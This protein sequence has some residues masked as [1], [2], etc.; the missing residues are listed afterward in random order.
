MA[1]QSEKKKIHFKRVPAL[2]KGFRMLEILS[3]AQAPMGVTELADR[4]GFHKSTVFNIMYTL[5]DLGVLEKAPANKVRLGMKFYTLSRPSAAG[6]FMISKIRPFLE[7]INRK[8]KLSVFLGVRSALKAVILDKVD[9]TQEI[10]VSSSRGMKIPLIAGSHGKALLSLLPE[11]QL[12]E[13]LV[14][15]NL[16]KFTAHTCTNPQSFK[17][18]VRK[19]A[20]DRFALDNEE[21]LEGIRSMAIPLNLGR[22]DVQTAIWLVGLKNQIADEMIPNFRDLLKKIGLQIETLFSR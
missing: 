2:D 22:P 19:T 20:R 9:S 16:K 6:V 3:E 21:Y 13:I 17:N 1:D 15:G 18:L 8:T 7:E 4:L 14:E 10:K 12:D 5:L 11:S